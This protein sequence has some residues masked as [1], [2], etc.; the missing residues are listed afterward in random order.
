MNPVSILK[1]PAVRA[2]VGFGRTTIY[3]LMQSGEFPRPRRI[4]ARAV[5]WDSR[6]IDQWIEQRLASA[7]P[8]LP[9]R[10]EEMRQLAFRRPRKTAPAAGE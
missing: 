10:S 2:R 7:P 6:E 5:G 4:A 8:A 9:E 1:L 3:S